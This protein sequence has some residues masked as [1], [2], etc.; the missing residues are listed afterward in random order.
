V[1]FRLLGKRLLNVPGINLINK[2]TFFPLYKIK[3]ENEISSECNSNHYII[4]GNEITGLISKRKI[5][6]KAPFSIDFAEFEITKFKNKPG[7][8]YLSNIRYDQS[9][10]NESSNDYLINSYFAYFT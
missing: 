9:P 7:D 10:T 2:D 1:D 5:D 3:Y 6:L 8:L 4:I